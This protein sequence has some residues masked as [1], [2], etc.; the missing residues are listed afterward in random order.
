MYIA[1]KVKPPLSF[2]AVKESCEQSLKRLQKD[3]IDIYFVHSNDPATPV[4]ETIAALE[5]LRS[6]GSIKH[7]GISHLPTERVNEYLEKGDVAFCLME[8]SAVARKSR[9]EL[10]P[11]C[12]K[13]EAKAIAFSVMGRGI[14]TGKFRQNEKFERGDIRNIDLLFKKVRFVSAMRITEKLEEIGEKYDKTSTQVAIN[15]V[16]SHKNVIS[17]LTGPSSK[18]HLEENVGGAGWEMKAEDVA[19]LEACLEKE[20]EILAEKEPEIIHEIMHSELPSAEEKAFNDLVYVI[21][22][23]IHQDMEEEKA[24]IPVFRELSSLRKG[25]SGIEREKLKESKE[26]IKRILF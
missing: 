17:A 15:W 16:L 21:E 25:K 23:S 26:K 24:M 4:R 8:L 1:T 13:Q 5:D 6:S 3:Q 18:E 14:L 2:H 7:Y 12:Q 9:K 22:A 20:D 11:L 19:E 10:L